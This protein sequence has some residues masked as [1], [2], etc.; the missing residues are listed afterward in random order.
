[1]HRGQN[2]ILQQQ[3]PARRG[4]VRGE[5]VAGEAMRAAR[6]RRGEADDGRGG[7][8]RRSRVGHQPY[9]TADRRRQRLRT[10]SKR[11]ETKR[12]QWDLYNSSNPV[13]PPCFALRSSPCR[14]CTLIQKLNYLMAFFQNLEGFILCLMVRGP[15]AITNYVYLTIKVREFSHKYQQAVLR[16]TI[17]GKVLSTQF[18]YTHRAL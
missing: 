1:M 9:I 6:R 11:K 17:M 14:F 10:S 5:A 4:H 8:G 12:F 16:C 3:H 15:G 13:L 18:V 7:G 2:Y